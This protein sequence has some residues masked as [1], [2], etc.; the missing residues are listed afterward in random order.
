L[1]NDIQLN[2]IYMKLEQRQR[3]CETARRNLET[4]QKYISLESTNV[5]NTIWNEHKKAF[6]EVI[7]TNLDVLINK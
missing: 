4:V 5:T 7:K 3:E 2:K 6:Q 1:D